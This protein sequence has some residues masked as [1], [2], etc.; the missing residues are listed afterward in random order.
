M[1]RNDKK[2]LKYELSLDLWGQVL[3]EPDSYLEESSV[4]RVFVN[5]A[6]AEEPSRWRKL[7]ANG[8]I[9]PPNMGT[10]WEL[11]EKH[12]KDLNEHDPDD[13]DDDV[14]EEI[15]SDT[16]DSNDDE[17]PSARKKKATKPKKVKKKESKH[18]HSLLSQQTSLS[19]SLTFCVPSFLSCRKVKA[20]R[21]QRLRRVRVRTGKRR[22][23]SSLHRGSRPGSHEHHF[24]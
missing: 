11:W 16:A 8:T 17:Q 13:G 1:C 15:S 22:A 10:W 3:P 9:K 20:I 5:L 14:E 12:Q 23:L 21:R 2:L 4:G 18:S 19:S 7:L 24:I 6:K